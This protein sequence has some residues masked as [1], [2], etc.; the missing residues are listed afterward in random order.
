VL[1]RDVAYASLPKGERADL[2]E[3]LG[4][5]LEDQP[6]AAAEIVGYH[7]E[8]A[9]HYR[10]D[11]G[12]PA[13]EQEKL[14]ARAAEHLGAAGEHALHRGDQIAASELLNRATTLLPVGTQGRLRRLPDLAEA[15]MYVGRQDRA[16]EVI[17]EA[18][19]GVRG[20]D[21]KRLELR[22]LMIEGELR[23][24]TDPGFSSD[25]FAEIAKR[26]IGVFEEAGDERGL[27]QSWDLMWEFH[28]WRMDADS[29]NES[30]ERMRDHAFRA[31]DPVL[32]ATALAHLVRPAMFGPWPVDECLRRCDAIGK[33]S[34]GHPWVDVAVLEAKGRLTALQGR[35]AEARS[36]LRQAEAIITDVG[37]R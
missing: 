24:D 14:A 35:F 17:D 4:D 25:E 9:V 31:N 11:I 26:A 34:R 2:H 19:Q 36:L 1:V 8:Q 23:S 10:E 18:I 28:W 12:L 30:A 22:T 27:A 7:F 20:T 6:D 29:A 21:D 37:T 5:W 13:D 32:E 16:R 3:S 33:A 15:L